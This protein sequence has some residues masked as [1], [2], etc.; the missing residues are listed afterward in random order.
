MKILIFGTF[1]TLHPGHEY[2][3]REALTRGETHIVVARDANVLRIKG[4]KPVQSEHTR[5]H[6]IEKAFPDATL[7]LGDIEDFLS[8]VRKIQPDLIL[9][10]YDQTMPP[11]V[12]EGDLGCPAERL[13]SFE[14]EKW[15]SSLS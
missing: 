11:G 4:K 7:H 9:L 1:D 6:A 8:P 15:K 2:V 13:E 5:C 12:K 3:I 10:G 14:P